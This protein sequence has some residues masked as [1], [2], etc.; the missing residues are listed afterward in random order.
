MMLIRKHQTF[1]IFVQLNVSVVVLA[2]ISIFSI[3]CK[4]IAKLIV[5]A[6]LAIR[7]KNAGIATQ[8]IVVQQQ[9][10]VDKFIIAAVEAIYL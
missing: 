6:K 4:R 2:L 3:V 10:L 8:R 9:E 7:L 1:R 5:V